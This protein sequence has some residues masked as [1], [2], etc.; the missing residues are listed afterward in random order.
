VIQEYGCATERFPLFCGSALVPAADPEEVGEEEVC[1]LVVVSDSLVEM[2]HYLFLR[3]VF[4]GSGS[5]AGVSL[6]L[7]HTETAARSILAIVTFPNEL[8]LV[9]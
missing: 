7:G 8:L 9:P 6:V 5:S 2:D 3:P 1:Y 4:L